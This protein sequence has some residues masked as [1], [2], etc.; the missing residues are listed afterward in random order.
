MV[1]L[2]RDAF[3]ILA[4]SI[5]L[6]TTIG[7]CIVFFFVAVVVLRLATRVAS[8]P[9]DIAASE[10]DANSC[11]ALD[12]SHNANIWL[13]DCHFIDNSRWTSIEIAVW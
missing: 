3:A 13:G 7:I 10:K 4:R 1:A 9:P 2:A 5:I 8:P 12:I 11:I 6:E